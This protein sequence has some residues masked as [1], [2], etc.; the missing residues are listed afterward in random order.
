MAA[1]ERIFRLLDEPLPAPPTEKSLPLSAPRG[2]IEFRNVWF[3]YHGGANPKEEDWVLR[4]VSFHIAPGQTLA[5]VGH[6]GAGKTTLI[7]LLLRFYEI[8]RGEILLDGVDVRRYD[9]HQLRQQFGIVLQDPFLFSGTL[10]TNVRLGNEE[11]TDASVEAALREVGLGTLLDTL[12]DGIKTN[13]SER[14]ATFSVGQRQLISFARALAH[15]PRFLILDEA[16]S[17]VDTKTEALIREA[18]DR[19]LEGRTAMV[20]AH[21]LSTIQHA[22]R[23]LVFHKGKLR[24]QGSHQQLLAVRGIYYR[25]YQLQYKD[26]ELRASFEPASSEAGTSIP[27]ND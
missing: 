12:P 16:T 22:D 25:L 27:G 20:I 15:N 24:E 18:L 14:G 7:Q 3:A 4:D 1:C 21:R 8:Q 9:V 26:Q 19:L 10:E 6:T 23:I 17:S 5:I 13:V 2:E 11:I